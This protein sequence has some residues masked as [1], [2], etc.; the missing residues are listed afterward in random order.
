MTEFEIEGATLALRL[1][2]LML[3]DSGAIDPDVL[4]VTAKS[5]LR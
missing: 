4:A 3:V 5:G 2:S 1:L